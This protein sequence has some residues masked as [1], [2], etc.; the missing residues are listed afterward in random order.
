[1][2]LNSLS[3]RL[4]PQQERLWSLQQ[5]AHGPAMMQAACMISLE[6]ELDYDAL[7]RAVLEVA[8]RHEILRTRFSG[9]RAKTFPDMVTDETPSVSF[10]VLPKKAGKRSNSL[11]ERPH[12]DLRTGPVFHACLVPE[13]GSHTLVCHLPGLCADQQ[14]LEVMMREIAACYAE[15]HG[16]GEC[17]SGPWQYKDFAAWQNEVLE[18][19]D[20]RVGRE[21]WSKQQLSPVLAYKLPFER[22]TGHT[23]FSPRSLRICLKPELVSA[24]E[25]VA[26]RI[27]VSERSFLFTAWSLVLSAYTGQR[28]LIVGCAFSGRPYPELEDG[29]GLYARYLPVSVSRTDVG[30]DELASAVDGIWREAKKRQSYFDWRKFQG[31]ER[32]GSA[33]PYFPFCFDYVSMPSAAAPGLRFSMQTSSVCFDRFNLRLVCARNDGGIGVTFDF[34]ESV[35]T[36][37]TIQ[38]I[39]ESYQQIL[40]SIVANPSCGVDRLELVSVGQRNKVLHE[41]NSPGEDYVPVCLPQ[42]F[43]RA[44]D[45]HPDNIAVISGNESLTYAEL[46]QKANRL[47]HYLRRLGAGPEEI[48]AVYLERS[49]SMMI[50]VLGILKAGAAFVLLETASPR[51]RLAFMLEDV[52]ARMLLTY[53]GHE[54]PPEK[55]PALLIDLAENEDFCG[56][57]V[58]N[59]GVAAGPDNLAYVIYTSGSTGKPKGILIDHG[60]ISLHSQYVRQCYGL[61]PEDRCVQFA[62]VNFDAAIEQMF[63]TLI[64]GAGLVLRDADLWPADLFVRKLRELNISI[65]N[66]PTAYWRQVGRELAREEVKEPLHR[67]KLIMIGGDAMYPD[68]VK[69][70]RNAAIPTDRLMHCYGPTE[71]TVYVT[72]LEVSQDMEGT[73]VD[74]R[75]S[76]GRPTHQRAVYILGPSGNPVPPGITG[77]IHIG[78][79]GLARG[80]LNAA[81]VTAEKF[82][83]DELSGMSGARLYRTGD[84]GRHLE[85]G[86]IEFLGRMDYQVKIRGYRVELGE[87]ESVLRDHAAV[88]DAVVI[89]RALEHGERQLVAYIVEKEG[90]VADAK[91]LRVYLA[92]R[93]PDYMVP[94]LLIKLN[95]L[96]TTAS[97]KT[98]LNA[99]PA[100]DETRAIGDR[101]EPAVNAVELALMKIWKESLG[102]KEVGRNDNFFA[103]GGDS[104]LAIQIVSR[105]NQ[106][107]LGLT[108]KH[109][110]Q[111]QTIAELAC[112]AADLNPPFIEEQKTTGICPL[113]P[114]QALFFERNLQNPNHYNQSV[115]LEPSQLLDGGLLGRAVAELIKHHDALRLRFDPHTQ[116]FRQSLDTGIQERESP[117]DVVDMRSLSAADQQELMQRHAAGVQSSLNLEQGPLLR[118]VLYEMGTTERVLLIVHHVAVDVV[119]WQILLEDLWRGYE[120]GA[121]GEQVNL[122]NMTTSYGS[123]AQKLEH[124]A[125]TADLVKEVEYWR[126]RIGEP[127][128]MDIPRDSNGENTEASAE[129]VGVEMSTEETE[130]LLR[131]V[132]RHERASASEVMIS[133]LGRVLRKWSGK[134]AVLVDIEGHGREE[135]VVTGVNLTRTVGWFTSIY[136]FKLESMGAG[137]S[138]RAELRRVKENLRQVPRSGLGYGLLKYKSRNQAVREHMRAIPSAQVS[139]NYLGQLDA[140]FSANK[141]FKLT[142]ERHGATIGPAEERNYFVEVRA[143]VLNQKLCFEWT[144][145]SNLHSRK[146]VQ[147]LAQNLVNEIRAV[148]NE[149]GSPESLTYRAEDF[150]ESGLSQSDLDALISQLDPSLK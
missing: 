52:N 30:F 111:H 149:D 107:G 112:A 51:E 139:F 98:D 25:Q 109:M 4:S 11:A 141:G 75:I 64:S 2:T 93:L 99:L 96:P 54:L 45:D 3:Y 18:A 68:D 39:T 131:D 137:E 37:S 125:G 115:M 70:W 114:I 133:S 144:Y 121:R 26:A 135:G 77:E 101:L 15:M 119:S 17:G 12:I 129:V 47:A 87:I 44:V 79:K 60:S 126:T 32:E 14:S 88:Q 85:D 128:N 122:G 89:T 150:V 59:L 65:I 48:V 102:L 132:A 130:K 22:K 19:E 81:D 95:S 104:I 124:M 78:G 53:R 66:P 73:A 82:I 136:P 117:F 20:T 36:E 94:P 86:S 84:L 123:W 145:S 90:K 42:L 106:A 113:T 67:L 28:E 76:I 29:I 146:T 91:D 33:M 9:D 103:L 8:G 110:F 83:P 147:S 100:P 63:S 92:S 55:L 35:L 50:A 108:Y 116:E 40:Q 142:T 6:G 80:Y 61:T 38:N 105:M 34:D 118:V 13:V 138:P 69:V 31:V 46:N 143:L 97:G 140:M 72:N 24:I 56:E 43:E 127:V 71:T 74:R 62:P 10:S 1:M 58:D 16:D 5:S 7:R 21:F 57:S 148:I 23:G 134:A 41:F 27:G 120:Q 49:P